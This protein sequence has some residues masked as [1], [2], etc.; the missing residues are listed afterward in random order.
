MSTGL[1]D[2]LLIDQR[3]TDTIEQIVHGL[4]NSLEEVEKKI[5][6]AILSPNKLYLLPAICETKSSSYMFA[7]AELSSFAM[8]YLHLSQDNEMKGLGFS[9][10]A[11][12]KIY[13][14]QVLKIYGIFRKPLT[15]DLIMSMQLK[16]K[17]ALEQ[18]K[19]KP[20][21]KKGD[22]PYDT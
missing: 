15:T 7:F 14:T 3:A 13:Q 4:N 18:N 6:I 19:V 5:K 12:L 8:N 16:I 11:E 2:Y 9:Y 22:N 10:D 1:T 20:K 21:E 17:K